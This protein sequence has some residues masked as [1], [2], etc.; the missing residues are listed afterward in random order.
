M[1][2]TIRIKRRASGSSGAPSSLKNGELAFNEVDNTLY[3]GKGTTGGGDTA[4]TVESIA[5]VGFAK[6]SDIPTNAD[7]VDRS[8]AQN[9]A[10]IKTLTSLL[11]PNAG[12]NVNSGKFTVTS[13]NGN[14]AIAGT[15]GVTGATTVSGT[16]NANGGIAVDTN[17]FTVAD[18]TGNIST[19]GNIAA[20]GSLQA[21]DGA[22]DVTSTGVITSGEYEASPIAAAYIGNLN[23]SKITAGE[24]PIA[25]GGTGAASATAAASA[26]GLGTEDSPTFAGG[27]VTGTLNAN[28]GINV[29][30]G[31]FTVSSTD[32]SITTSNGSFVIDG[33]G[34]ITS[35]EYEASP[36]AAAY[37]GSLPA[38][39]ITTGEL[40]IARGGTGA[41]S[42][43][44]AASA[45]GLGT[46][47]SP[48][49]TQVT[50]S[51][52]GG[53][54][55][56]GAGLT[57][58]PAGQLT[59]NIN[60]A[61]L[62][63]ATATERGAIELF[64]GTAQS[65]AA[66][67]VTTTAS[68]TYGIQLNSAGQAVVNVPWENDNTQLTTAQVRSKISGTGLI[69]YDTSTGVISTTANNYSLPEATATVRGGIELFSNDEQSV[70]ANSVT[71]TASRTYGIQLNSAGQAV[72][73][74]PWSDTDTNTQLTDAQVRSKIS[75]TGLISYNDST[76]VIST[77]A[78]NY[79]LPVATATVKGGIELFSNTAQSVA[80]NA[81]S[82]TASRTY[83]IQLNSAGQA[84]VNVPWTD[85]SS[86]TRASLNIDTDDDVVFKN[87]ELG[88]ASGS[89]TIKGPAE[90]VIDP[91]THGDAGGSVV[92]EGNLQVKGTTTT[93]NSTVVEV[94]DLALDLA[95]EKTSLSLIDGAGIRLGDDGN[96]PKGG[97]VEFVYSH[98]NTRMELSS[99]LH[100]NG[101]LKASSLVGCT[102][103]GGTF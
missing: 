21:A 78:N 1:S 61:R 9:V 72:V 36:I 4:A 101:G 6:T 37:I 88:G 33:N 103:D 102:I 34:H 86:S 97:L 23:A 26:L 29:N 41:A 96:S 30:S 47:D 11:K 82:T 39:K 38:S 49:F 94:A 25:R 90:L 42:A 27:T 7:F 24:L 44:A 17:K 3:Y 92:I 20:T 85:S 74:V 10:G 64:S 16:L 12:I 71:D 31:K 45:L 83:G 32:G 51:G 18:G 67:T 100:V 59:G 19:A 28:G 40:P 5:G 14:T 70:A 80:A 60:T 76:G 62:P 73:N 22:F 15:L 8:T 91:A 79:V 58:I 50:V 68:R 63:V 93:V 56:S 13:S 89:A 57:S 75:G 46:E 53:F 65:V 2:N 66:N 54:V 81:V 55:G 95:S 98:S 35:G 52:S 48:T 99:A 84:V 69:S 87:L 77:T 43:T